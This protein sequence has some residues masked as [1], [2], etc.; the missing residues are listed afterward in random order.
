MGISGYELGA[1]GRS[2]SAAKRDARAKDLL[3]LLI[4]G[5]AARRATAPRDLFR[6]VDL[7][8][9]DFT[10]TN[11]V[12]CA[13][14]EEALARGAIAPCPE[15]PDTWRL[16]PAGQDDLGLL[17]ATP[18]YDASGPLGRVAARLQVGLLDLLPEDH[19]TAALDRLV[20]VARRDDEAAAR[21][22]AAPWAGPC[23]EV[24]QASE[25]SA[26]RHLAAAR[27]L[28]RGQGRTA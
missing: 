23:A 8:A 1:A 20:A 17:L 14:I 21:M 10:P 9:P 26:A 13:C 2:A 11:E 24:W 6:A 15:A 18:G 4:L 12:V 16:T 3:W 19:R 27:V 22:M 28:A 7:L 5:L 25:R